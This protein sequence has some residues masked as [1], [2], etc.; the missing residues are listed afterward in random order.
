MSVQFTYTLAALMLSAT[1]NAFMFDIIHHVLIDG[2][3]AVIML[4]FLTTAF[5]LN[6][7][8]HTLMPQLQEHLGLCYLAQRH[9]DLILL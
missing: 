7:H 2:K 4:H 8:I 9:S 1:I 3:Q 6:N 5:I